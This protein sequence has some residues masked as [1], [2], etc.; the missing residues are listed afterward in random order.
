MLPRS[1]ERRIVGG[2][3][4]AGGEPVTIGGIEARRYAAVPLQG[5]DRRLTAYTVATSDG[6]VAV[7]C[8]APAE[9]GIASS[10][11]TTAGSLQIRRGEPLP[12]TPDPEYGAAIDGLIGG[13]QVQRRTLRQRLGKANTRFQQQEAAGRLREVYQRAARR[14]RQ[15]KPAP[16]AAAAHA[17]L[18]DALRDTAEAYGRLQGFAIA[19]EPPKWLVATEWISDREAD[20][21]GALDALKPLGYTIQ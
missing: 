14:L 21:Q 12:L 5:S 1:L 2:L 13:I 8:Y 11:G 6:V 19:N 17:D 7:A 4:A 15:I 3:P 20:V 18:E 16:A 9:D 10:C